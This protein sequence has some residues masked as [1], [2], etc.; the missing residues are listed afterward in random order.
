MNYVLLFIPLPSDKKVLWFHIPVDEVLG[1]H[2]FHAGD[3]SK[4]KKKKWHRTYNTA[5]EI[6]NQRNDFE[7]L[8]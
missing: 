8:Q 1:V 3:L 7:Q 5:E 2:V 4:V 6:E